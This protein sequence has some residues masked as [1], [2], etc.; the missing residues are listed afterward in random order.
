PR[1]APFALWSAI[2][3]TP[4]FIRSI[5][6]SAP[7]NRFHISHP[8]DFLKEIFM[9]CYNFKIFRRPKFHLSFCFLH[10]FD[11]Y[12]WLLQVSTSAPPLSFFLIVLFCEITCQPVVLLIFV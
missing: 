9:C 4:F 12:F 8:A 11:C 7:S 1:N 10:N 5:V 3:L 2:I 6:H